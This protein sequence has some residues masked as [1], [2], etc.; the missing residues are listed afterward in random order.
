MRR[1]LLL[2]LAAACGG[3]DGGPPDTPPAPIGSPEVHYPTD[4]YAQG[5][6]GSVQLRLFVDSAGQVIPE[7]TVV[8]Q[9]SG[10][11]PLDSAAVAA[12]PGF[13]YTPARRQ[14]R[15]VATTLLQPVHFRHPS[16]PDSAP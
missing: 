5:V 8:D 14:G 4:L 13:R 11:P 10:H 9:S 7:S 2:P 16:Q 15:P 1:F 3:G 12:A 6:G